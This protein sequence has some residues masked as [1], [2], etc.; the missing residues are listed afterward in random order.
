[1][2]SAK[3]KSAYLVRKV[4]VRAT[5]LSFSVGDEL[6]IKERDSRYP[7]I[8]KT[9]KDLSKRLGVKFIVTIAGIAEGT[10]IK[11]VQ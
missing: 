9:A 11:R 1:M 3:Q 2:E 8:Y 10:F 4:D 7:T 5:L 6:V